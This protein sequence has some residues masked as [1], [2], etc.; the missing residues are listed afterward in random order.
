MKRRTGR[1]LD[2]TLARFTGDDVMAAFAAWARE[3]PGRRVELTWDESGLM[4][5]FR[6]GPTERRKRRKSIEAAVA[7]ALRY[8]DPK[9]RAKVLERIAR[10][11]K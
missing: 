8:L 5:C 10:R 9:Q 1:T 7:D 11:A 3:R 2:E 4:C 6:P